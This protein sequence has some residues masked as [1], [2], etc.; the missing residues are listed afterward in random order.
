M[1]V[2]RETVLTKSAAAVQIYSNEIVGDLFKGNQ[3]AVLTKDA[4]FLLLLAINNNIG[5]RTL[6]VFNTEPA[7]RD[8]FRLSGDSSSFL[9]FPPK[10]PMAEFRGSKTN[11][12]DTVKKLLLACLVSLIIFCALHVILFLKRRIYRLRLMLFFLC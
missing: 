10:K 5:G 11:R 2:S 4:L 1:P 7:A 3:L 6:L 12:I 9:F 8:V